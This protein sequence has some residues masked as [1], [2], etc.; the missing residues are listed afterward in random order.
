MAIPTDM[1]DNKTTSDN[2]GLYSEGGAVLF[3]SALQHRQA[4]RSAKLQQRLASMRNSQNLVNYSNKLDALSVRQTLQTEEMLSSSRDTVLQSQ[5]QVATATARAAETGVSAEGILNASK[6]MAERNA[7]ARKQGL[8]GIKQSGR[9]QKQ[10]AYSQF[11]AGHQTVVDNSPS[12][13]EILTS[14]ILA[15]SIKFTGG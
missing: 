11:L 15:S 1:G 5:R 14:N 4:Q 3:Q 10:D 2:S 7:R 8:Q 12:F 9:L 13:S 6:I